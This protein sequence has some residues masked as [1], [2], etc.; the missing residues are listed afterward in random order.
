MCPASLRLM[1]P[2]QG[3][4]QQQAGCSLHLFTFEWPKLNGGDLLPL[5]ASP[6]LPLITPHLHVHV[7]QLLPQ[8]VVLLLAFLPLLLHLG[9]QRRVA[10]VHQF[11]NLRHRGIGQYLYNRGDLRLE[12]DT[13]RHHH[14][15][16]LSVAARTDVCGGTRVST[17]QQT[18]M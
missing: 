1:S 5:T 6:H 17:D 16:C 13:V 14:Q 9:A 8:D 4:C 11:A 15:V 12:A 18:G 3:C 2:N 10:I 7:S